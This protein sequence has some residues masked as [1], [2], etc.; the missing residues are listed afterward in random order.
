M[1]IYIFISSPRTGY[2]H[3]PAVAQMSGVHQFNG[4]QTTG[5]YVYRD[6]PGSVDEDDVSLTN[7]CP[8]YSGYDTPLEYQAY[9]RMANRRGGQVAIR[10]NVMGRPDT[11]M[12]M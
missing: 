11:P 3:P 7:Y 10:Y 6:A 1:Y 8:S 2:G 5:H 4:Q 12:A 9:G